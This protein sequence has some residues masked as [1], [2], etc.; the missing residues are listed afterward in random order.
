VKPK[1]VQ[2]FIDRFDP[3]T[4]VIVSGGARG[5]D[6]IA[7]EHARSRGMEVIEIPADWKK[8]GRGAGFKRNG[9]IVK[10]SDSVAAF[11]NGES[12]GTLD[13]VKKGIK[14]NRPTALFTADGQLMQF[15]PSRAQALQAVPKGKP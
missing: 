14:L 13:T 15:T 2:K 4:T 12:R 1:V 6:Q 8:H 9:D 11:W 3:L 10:R 5:V 7:A